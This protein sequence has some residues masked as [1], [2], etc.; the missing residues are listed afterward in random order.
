MNHQGLIQ[1]TNL[2]ASRPLV[3]QN[4]TQV[5]EHSL[6]QPHVQVMQVM[7]AATRALYLDHS[8]SLRVKFHR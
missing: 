6:R 1:H 5:I 8:Y 3:P 4:P 2:A 7:A